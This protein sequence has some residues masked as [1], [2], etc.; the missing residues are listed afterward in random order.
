MSLKQMNRKQHTRFQ[1]SSFMA[2]HTLVE[3]RGVRVSQ[4]HFVSML[5]TAS[6]KCLR[7]EKA[8]VL[9]YVQGSTCS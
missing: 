9:W 8:T 3:T 4:M 1:F 5:H 6:T 2:V 7:Q